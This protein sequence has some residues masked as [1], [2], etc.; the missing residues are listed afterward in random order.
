[1]RTNGAGQSD[2]RGR[3]MRSAVRPSPSGPPGVRYLFAK[4]PRPE[5]AAAGA[6]PPAGPQRLWKGADRP[7]APWADKSRLGRASESRAPP[8]AE[9]P[10]RPTQQPGRCEGRSHAAGERPLAWREA[11][12][13][14]GVPPAGN[15]A[16]W[17]LSSRESHGAGRSLSHAPLGRRRAPL[18]LQ[19]RFHAL[20][21]R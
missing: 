21:H 6:S 14:L 19:P 9:F 16:H 8:E 7:E 13:G 18:G 2:C 17:L 3:R 1:M 20:L 4:P 11:A 15:G 10:A 12:R 5:A